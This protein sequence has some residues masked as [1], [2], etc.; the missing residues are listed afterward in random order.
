LEYFINILLLDQVETNISGLKTILTNSGNNLIITRTV[1]AAIDEIN[2]REIGILLVNISNEPEK[3]FRQLDKLRKCK[4]ENNFYTLLICSDEMSQGKIVKG[5]DKGAVDYIKYPF[6]PNLVKAKINVFKTLYFKD[7]RINQ[8]LKNIFPQNVLDSLNSVGK[9]SPQRIEEGTVLFTDFIAFSKIAKNTK[10]LS[11]IKKLERY[12]NKFDEITKRYKLEKIKTIGDAYMALAGVTEN[13]PNPA[14]RAC[15]AALE[16]RD[17]MINDGSFARAV[18]EDFWSI[19]IGIHSGPLVA[20][21]IGNQKMSFDVWGDTVNI[22]ARAEQNSKANSITVT[23]K[24]ASHVTSYFNL[25]H[26]GEIKIKYGDVVD[27]YFLEHLKSRYSL[28]NEGKLPTRPLRKRCGLIGLDF[29]NARRNILNKLKSSL[30]E[31]LTYHDV[32]HTLS[33]E[34]AALRLAKLEGVEGEDLIL[35]RTA[36]LFHDA[37]YIVQYKDNEEYGVVLMKNHLPNF[38]YTQQQIKIIEGIILATKRNVKPLTVLEKI[39]CDADHDY[40]GRADYFFL[41]DQLRREIKN[42]GTI[43]TDPEWRD[44]QIRY[45]KDIHSYYTETALNIREKGKQR[46]IKELLSQ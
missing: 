40:L 45:L 9:F 19:R 7:I 16:M 14:V 35:L 32:K 13:H 42:H 33:V 2:K 30:P 46:R 11:L 34:Q 27:M 20:G 8:L 15:L 25:T 31:D 12:F 21:I 36:V 43:M 4:N 38:G 6:N 3:S 44:Y 22:A 18:G 39:M 26:R 10:P 37:G 1:E 24:V 5:F 17:Y 28:F 41:A 29:E 23:D